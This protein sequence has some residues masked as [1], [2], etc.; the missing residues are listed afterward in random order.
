MFP[1]RLVHGYFYFEGRPEKIGVYVQE[2]G[3]RSVKV[4]HGRAC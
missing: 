3:F 2:A 4:D 1:R